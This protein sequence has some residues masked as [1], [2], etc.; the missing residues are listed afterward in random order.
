VPRKWHETIEN[1]HMTKNSKKTW[2]HKKKLNGNQTIQTSCVNVTAYQVASELLHNG[3]PN[4]KV[5]KKRSRE[6]EIF[7]VIN[8]TIILQLKS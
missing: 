5:K 6:I 1:I 2:G 4:T 7:N 3:K 8:F